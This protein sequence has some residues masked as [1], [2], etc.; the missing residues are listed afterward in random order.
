MP[1]TDAMRM[2]CGVPVMV[3]TLPTLEAVA[4]ARRCGLGSHSMDSAMWITSGVKAMHTTSL[5]R[6]AESTAE[7]SDTR[8]RSARGLDARRVT[9][10]PTRAKAPETS[11]AAESTII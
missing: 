11:S 9:H 7:A 3:A 8:T 6:K 4:S 5:I 10:Q 1:E 2:F